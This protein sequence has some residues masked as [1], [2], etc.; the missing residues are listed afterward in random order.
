MLYSLIDKKAT[1]PSGLATAVPGRTSWT[2]SFGENLSTPSLN[3]MRSSVTTCF[4]I[5]KGRCEAKATAQNEDRSTNVCLMLP[6]GPARVLN[7]YFSNLLL[8]HH[9]NRRLRP[10]FFPHR[11]DDN[12]HTTKRIQVC[13]F[14]HYGK[15]C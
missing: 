12:R 7:Q 1:P 10:F 11:A 2:R 15:C 4:D 3:G 8:C 5:M 13:I 9:A 14:W 6:E